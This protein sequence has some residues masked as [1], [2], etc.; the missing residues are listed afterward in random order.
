M[1]LFQSVKMEYSKVQWPA[2]QQIITSTAWVI[3]MTILISVYLG[4]YDFL[5]LRCLNFLEAII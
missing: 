3:T 1:N 2:K 4:I 5:V